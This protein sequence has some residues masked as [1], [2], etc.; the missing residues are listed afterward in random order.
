LPG[1]GKTIFA[2]AA[3]E[4]LQAIRIRS[5]VERKRLFGLMPLADSRELGD[6]VYAADATQH[7]YAR[8]HELA[9]ELLMAGTTVIVDAA[10][11]KRSER[12]HFRGLAHELGVPFA[13]ASMRA[14]ERD[15]TTRITRRLSESHDASEADLVVLKSLQSKQETLSPTEQAHAAAFLNEGEEFAIDASAWRKLGRLISV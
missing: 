1:S 6:A 13:I 3:L 7:T 2:Q 15:L 10:F 9:R 4:R 14:S 11:L 8:L 5:D 12:E